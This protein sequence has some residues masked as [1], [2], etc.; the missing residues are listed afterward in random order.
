MDI[1]SY[2]HDKGWNWKEV[3]R[4]KGLTAI[5]NCLFCDD[6][7]QKMAVSLVDGAFSC[8]H[9]NNCGAK[10][11][12]WDLQKMLGDKPQRL[13]GDKYIVN[14]PVK[15]KRPETHSEK[16]T[17]QA[18]EYLKSRGIAEMIISQFKIGQ[19]GNEIMFPY[20]K[21]GELVN[22]KYRSLKEKKFRQEKNA[23]PSLFGR[24]F[25]TGDYVVICEGEIDAMSLSQ[26]GEPAVSIPSG[27]KDKRWIE[28]EWDF[29]QKFQK[30]YLMFD[31]DTAGQENIFDIVKRL[32]MWRCYNVI[33]PYKDANECLN[34]NIFDFK[35]YLDLAKEYDPE[36]LK[37]A[38]KFTDEV[39][40]LFEHPEVLYGTGYPWEQL[41]KI[42]RGRRDGELTIISGRNSSGKTTWLNQVIIHFLKKEHPTIIASLEIPARRYLRWM[43]LN[44][45][46]TQSP[47]IKNVK[48]TME[49]IGE[50][51]Y[52][53]DVYGAVTPYDLLDTFEFASRKYG[54]K[55]YVIDSLLKIDFPGISDLKEQK[56]F[57]NNCIDKLCKYHNGHVYL[58]AHPR[59]G[60]RDSG[61]PDKV[62]IEGT[63]A[64]SNLADNILIMRRISEEEKELKPNLADNILYVKKGREWG[65]E[66][67]VNFSFDKESKTFSEI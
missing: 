55:N 29:L 4:P 67:H 62:D 43:V 51:L 42:L 45:L 66:G 59:K 20:F 52:V 33:L 5:G 7:E 30:I 57:V 39:I 34:N 56:E 35:E 61:T 50:K 14:Q 47:N 23:E 27:A 63:G 64:I 38:A 24:D 15:Y 40:E 19:H 54:I 3:Q 1:R 31:N 37:N 8:M 10:G 49:W 44:I 22:V 28:T 9:L 2:L 48:T 53:L 12:W 18:I 21:N 26:C 36:I 25:C 60:E 6:R 13:D 17:T 11:S 46:G 58:V 65:D 16:F 32:G 41:N